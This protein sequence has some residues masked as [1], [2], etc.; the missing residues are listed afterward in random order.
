LLTR[1]SFSIFIHSLTHAS[2]RVFEE[3]SKSA[4]PCNGLNF[5]DWTKARACVC[6]YLCKIIIHA[7][8]WRRWRGKNNFEVGKR[9]W[10]A[11][12]LKNN[13]EKRQN[14]SPADNTSVVASAQECEQLSSM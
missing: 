7:W 11:Q 5:V 2:K 10:Q 3:V 1:V 6:C 14:E 8:K 4:V 13:S 12:Q 9:E